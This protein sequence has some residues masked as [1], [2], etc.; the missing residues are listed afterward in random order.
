M[1]QAKTLL[2]K[3]FLVSLTAIF[4]VTIIS[5]YKT[6]VIHAVGSVPQDCQQITNVNPRNA[7]YCNPSCSRTSCIFYCPAYKNG[8]HIKVKSDFTDLIIKYKAPTH[9]IYITVPGTSI[10]NYEA[11]CS[12]KVCVGQIKDTSHTIFKKG[13]ILT[14]IIRDREGNAIGYRAPDSANNC[15]ENNICREDGGHY[16]TFNISDITTT[17]DKDHAL[18]SKQCYGDSPIGDSDFDF[19]DYALTL[20][21]KPI[22][23]VGKDPFCVKLTPHG[24]A[25]SPTDHSYKF[26]CSVRGNVNA[27]K[28]KIGNK[29][30]TSKLNDPN[31]CV[32]NYTFTKPGDYKVTCYAVNTNKEVTNGMCTQL[33]H[34][35]EDTSGDIIIPVTVAVLTGLIFLVKGGQALLHKKVYITIKHT[36]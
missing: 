28:F 31:G 6:S 8:A 17:P 36:K 13:Q 12:S 16:G 24:N 22:P 29:I 21:G 18:I 10:Q 25:N 19:N 4:L 35:P 1:K 5:T 9:P 7:P 33:I 34:I 14:I 11:N 30:I 32:I 15:G 26:V 27:C 2:T 20:F 23:I 3:I